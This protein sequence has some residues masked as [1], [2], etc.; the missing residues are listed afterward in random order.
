M[1]KA[2]EKHAQRLEALSLLGKDLTRRSSAHCELCG[3][4]G[5]KLAPYEVE[6][7]Q[8]SPDT[9]HTV[10]TCQVCSEQLQ[11]PKHLSVDHWRCLNTSVWSEVAP[12]QVV[13]VRMLEHLAEKV[14]WAADLHEQLYLEPE[15]EEW[16]SLARI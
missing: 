13:A 6:P 14:E 11:K 16:V 3:A 7:V 4:S 8:D 9:D 10:F 12:V 1:S 5:V 2:R 15:I